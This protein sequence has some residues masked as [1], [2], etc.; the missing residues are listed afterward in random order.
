MLGAGIL[1]LIPYSNYLLL[2]GGQS[3]ASIP[4]AVASGAM[5]GLA[6]EAPALAGLVTGRPTEIPALLP[7]LLPLAQRA[8]VYLV[9]GGGLL[10]LSSS[11]VGS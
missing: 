4:L 2:L 5:F 11:L 9:A 10:L 7:R 1:T 3:V 8:N 6:R